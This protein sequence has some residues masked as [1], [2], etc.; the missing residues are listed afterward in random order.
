MKNPLTNLG[1]PQISWSQLPHSG[2]TFTCL[3]KEFGE[4]NTITVKN[5]INAYYEYHVLN[6]IGIDEIDLKANL[7]M[8]LILPVKSWDIAVQHYGNRDQLKD[9][10]TSGLIIRFTRVSK[11]KIKINKMWLGTPENVIL[12][13][14]EV[15]DKD[16]FE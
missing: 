7:Q 12:V 11:K 6:I 9:Y 5:N 1:K 8:T 10:R 16:I 3:F 4:M 14:Q 15:K 2:I 13:Q